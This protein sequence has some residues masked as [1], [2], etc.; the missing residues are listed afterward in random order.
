MA[1]LVAAVLVAFVLQRFVV[2]AFY[3]PSASMETT[4]LPG[5]RVLVNKL[6]YDF[7]AVHRGDVVVFVKPSNDPTPNIRD[8]IKR[9]IGLP[10]ETIASGPTGDVLIDGKPIAQPWLTAAARQS[11]GPPIQA[12]VIPKGEYFV[13]GDNRSDSADSRVIGPVSTKLIVGRAFVL[14]WPFSRMGFL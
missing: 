13:M 1:I 4:L 5:D 11:P 12:Q 8:L 6:S 14:V 10:G 9:V 2:Q 7:H 3:I